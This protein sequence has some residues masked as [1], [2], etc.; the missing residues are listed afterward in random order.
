MI[1][2]CVALPKCLRTIC[3]LTVVAISGGCS[4]PAIKSRATVAPSAMPG[5]VRELIR[6][7]DDALVAATAN[8]SGGATEMENALVALAKALTLE[9]ASYEAA[10]KAARAAAWLADDYYDDK[11]KRAYFANQGVQ[12]AKRAIKANPKSVEGHYYSGIDAGFEA[13]T[14]SAVVA[15]FMVPSIRDSWKRAIE[16][17][18]RFDHGGPSRALGSLYTQAPLWPASIGDPEKGVELLK[19]ALSMAPDYV[20]NDLL[21]GDALVADE[22]YSEAKQHYEKVLRAEPQ[23]DNA[24]FLSRWKSRAERKLQQIAQKQAP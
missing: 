2:K 12:Y 13:T 10:W 20:L 23:A 9:P 1:G 5:N 15:K 11:E 17:D 21:L 6:F 22:Q 8:A 4:V 18:P 7:A 24:H 14:R 16:L 19:Q 3:M